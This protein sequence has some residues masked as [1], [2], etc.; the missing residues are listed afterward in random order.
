MHK[1]VLSILEAVPIP[2]MAEVTQVFNQD[3]LKDCVAE[4]MDQLESSGV[5]EQIK[6][7][8]NIAITGGSR[9][10]SNISALTKATGNFVKSKGANPFVVPAMGS[11]GGAT[12]QGQ[13]DLLAQYGITEK[14]VDM[15][16]LS[17]MEV[18]KIG[19]LRDATPV[20]FDKLAYQADGII[21]INRIK[22]HT[23]FRARYESGLMKML[24]VGLGKQEGADA[25]HA[26]GL[27]QLGLYVEEAGKYLLDHTKVILGIAILENAYDETCCIRVLRREEIAEEEPKLLIESKKNLP[28]IKFKDLD[29]LLI[30]KIGKNYSGA[31]MD[32]NITGKFVNPSIESNP[33]SKIIAVLDLSEETEG[34]G[35]GIG[36]ADVTTKRVVNKLDY[37]SMYMN[38]LTSGVTESSKIPMFY[39]NDKQAIQAAIKLSK[40]LNPKNLRMVRIENTLDL[41]RIMISESLAEE[42]K[43]RKDIIFNEEFHDLTFN[44]E[45]NLF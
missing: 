42:A 6:A 41:S 5:G 43:M 12:D 8:M 24:S 3:S 29:L 38:G 20:Y 9:G 34:N 32:P 25:Y 27:D 14:Q 10:I 13:K 15:P 28:C 36:L 11:H 44:E 19:E 23:G 39:D 2:K 7:G 33:I 30:D 16:I 18:V 1:S 26:K 31:G 21:I 45:N 37:A 4:L 17:S 35:N 22:M 40:Q